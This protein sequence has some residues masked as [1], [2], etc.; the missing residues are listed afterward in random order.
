M[1]PEGSLPCS[2]EPATCPYPALIITTTEKY[3]SERN[4]TEDPDKKKV[5]ILTH[6]YHVR[7][8]D[9]MIKKSKKFLKALH[10][11]STCITN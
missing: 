10:E 8:P 2:Q 4:M 3:D 6:K 9:A 11:C 5:L 1:E 7:M